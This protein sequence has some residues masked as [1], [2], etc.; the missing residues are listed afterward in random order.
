MYTIDNILTHTTHRPWPLPVRRWAYYQEW[1]RTLFLHWKVEPTT[2]AQLVPA[3]LTIDT[4]D[5][6]AWISLV[7]FTMEKV[8]PRVLPAFAPISNFHEVNVRTY[9]TAQDQPGVYFLSLEAQKYLSTHIARQ[10][11]GLPYERSVMNRQ[12]QATR[13]SY[14]SANPAKGFRLQAD[15][16][17]GAVIHHKTPLDTWLTERYCTYFGYKDQ[18]YR[19]NIHHHPWPLQEVQFKHLDISY[20]FGPISLHPPFILAHYSEGVQSIAWDRESVLP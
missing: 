10:L 17:T 1:N 13:H 6:A 20:T 5:G 11:S 7:A 4:M 15:F 9:V 19:Y 14:L 8:R 12:N 3:Q 16:E 2:I 18:L